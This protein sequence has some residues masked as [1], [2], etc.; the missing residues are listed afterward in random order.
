MARWVDPPHIIWNSR[1]VSS[2][3]YTYDYD[4]SAYEEV[5]VWVTVTGIAG[6]P[7]SAELGMLANRKD[8]STLTQV[9]DSL[10]DWNLITGSSI[11]SITT[12]SNSSGLPEGAFMQL[13]SSHL[14]GRVQI[15]VTVD[16]SGGTAPS[17]TT[18]LTALLKG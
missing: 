17:L 18:T 13:T 11:T 14:N 10:A 3:T 12:D 9:N 6:D 7:S 5:N 1:A 8:P 4:W 16:A 2:G 15:A